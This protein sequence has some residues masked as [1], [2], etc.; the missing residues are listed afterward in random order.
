M[1]MSVKLS[2]ELIGKARQYGG[3]YRRSIS[4][5]IEHWSLIGKIVEENP[6]QPYSFIKDILLAQQEAADG[7]VI[8]FE[9]G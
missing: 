3:I 4:K 8:L 6:D 9:F 7:E 5:Q 2:D 1:P